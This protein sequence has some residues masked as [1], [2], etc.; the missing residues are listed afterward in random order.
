MRFVIEVQADVL[1][2]VLEELVSSPIA[3][4]VLPLTLI[5]TPVLVDERSQAV[6]FAFLEGA[7]VQSVL[8][9]LY[10]EFISLHNLLVIKEL[11]DHLILCRFLFFIED[12][13][14]KLVISK[15]LNH[16]NVCPLN[17]ARILADGLWQAVGNHLGWNRLLLSLLLNLL[18]LRHLLWLMSWSIIWLLL[19]LFFFLMLILDFWL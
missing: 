2:R 12:A 10:V 15:E 9:A 17:S 18:L 7:L 13:P 14:C 19:L 3:P 5:D 6:P 4:I 1:Y 8:R 16:V 11:A